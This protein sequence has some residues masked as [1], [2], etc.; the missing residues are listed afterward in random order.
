MIEAAE[1]ELAFIAACREEIAAPKPGNVHI[2]SAGHGMTAEH[3]YLSAE[4]AAGPLC[5][6]GKPVG[7]RIH[8][9]VAASFAAVG[10]NT[11]L[12][13]L[14]LCAPLAAAA[15]R[16][17]ASLQT[18]LAK[19]LAALDAKDT[20]HVFAAI[21]LA[22]PGGLGTA[23]R[24]DV[25]GPADATLGAAMAEAAERDRIALQYVSNFNDVFVTGFA[26]LDAAHACGL[27]PPWSTIAV[28]LKFLSTF[29]DS[30]LLRKQGAAAALETQREAAEM[31]SFFQ[32]GGEACLADLLAF[33]ARL[34]SSNRNPG[35]SADL[36]VAT[37]FA[38]R[39]RSILLKPHNDG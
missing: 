10:L 20:Q 32:A 22:S 27:K 33:D 29:P 31:L 16:G 39:L 4:A 28:Y 23:E 11:N 9:A 38:D 2:F 14:L 8:D 15:E 37:L 13:I 30:H 36:T 35:T 18:E 26:T 34:K 12:G 7:Q 17:G 6:P 21:R 24:Y 25:H 5:V 3:F 19:V 1:I